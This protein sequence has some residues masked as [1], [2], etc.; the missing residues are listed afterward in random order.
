MKRLPI[1]CL[2]VS[3]AMSLHAAAAEPPVTFNRHIAPL[4]YENCMVCHRA[5]E[6]GPFPLTTYAE[7]KKK[8]ETIATA[9]GDKVMPPWRA[10]AGA[11]TFHDARALKP[12]QIAL[13][14]QGM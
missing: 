2:S 1:L 5:G 4:V 13:F 11:E 3:A 8:A 14:E 9:L 10:D 6:V 12:E 7:V